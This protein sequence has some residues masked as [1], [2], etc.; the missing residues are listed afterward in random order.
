MRVRRQRA[1]G[2]WSWVDLRLVP[3]AATVWALTL[4]APSLSAPVLGAG[5]VGCA[6]A[7]AVLL[8]RGAGRTVHPGIRRGRRR[9]I[10]AWCLDAA[11]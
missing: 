5:A 8:R 4:V 6:G 10:A 2:R 3:A 1:D 11:T 7:A 9:K